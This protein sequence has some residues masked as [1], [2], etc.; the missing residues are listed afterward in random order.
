[1]MAA[2]LRDHGVRTLHGW[3]MTETTSG[4]TISCAPN[5]LTED[6]TLAAMGTQGKPLFGNAIRIVDDADMIPPNDGKTPGHLQAL[7]PGSPA[8]ISSAPTSNRRRQMAGWRP[9]TSP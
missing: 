6:A 5:G 3:G 4:A 7:A 8:P 9:A 2:Y 1:M